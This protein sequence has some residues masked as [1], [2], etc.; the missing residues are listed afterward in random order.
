MAVVSIG[1]NETDGLTGTC[2]LR[3]ELSSEVLIARGLGYSEIG[4]IF[5]FSAGLGLGRL[6]RL[7]GGGFWKSCGSLW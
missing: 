2:I 1:G 7:L 3:I 5:L 6:H 4:S